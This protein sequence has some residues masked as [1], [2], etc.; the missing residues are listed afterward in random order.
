MAKFRVRLSGKSS[1]SEY[2][3]Y[4][5]VNMV[6]FIRLSPETERRLSSP[7][8][9]TG[10]T[11]GFYIRQIIE[12][13]LEDVKDYYLAADVLDR[14]RKGHEQLHTADA[15][16]KKLG[17]EASSFGPAIRVGPL[18]PLQRM[19]IGPK[20]H[21]PDD[22]DSPVRLPSGSFCER[23]DVVLDNDYR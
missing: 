4:A 5:L 3:Y 18:R 21:D 16:R 14:I 19:A 17:L 6:T 22:P 10:R 20:D 8:S 9:Q 15:V 1:Y 2:G 23:R 11:K 13:G 7:A 12:H